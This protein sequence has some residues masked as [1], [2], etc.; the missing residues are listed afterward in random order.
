MHG[1]AH[2]DGEKA[3]SR[4]AA[5]LGLAMGLS[6]Y[7]TVSLE[8]VISQ[9]GQARNPYAFQ[10]SIVKDRETSLQWIKQAEGLYF[11]PFQNLKGRAA[12]C[13]LHVQSHQLS[14]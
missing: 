3:T 8:D 12:K 11:I 14:L 4:A 6:T 5:K 9:R 1:L 10:L 13:V 7:S 2:P